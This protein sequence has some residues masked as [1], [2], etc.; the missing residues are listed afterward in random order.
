MGLENTWVAWCFDNAISWGG[1]KIESRII[2]DKKTGRAKNL[3]AILAGRYDSLEG[4]VAGLQAAGIR[5]IG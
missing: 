4:W 3:E 5:G 2:Y 1:N